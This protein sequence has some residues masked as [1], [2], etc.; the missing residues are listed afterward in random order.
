MTTGMVLKKPRSS[1]LLI[2]TKF[3]MDV[4]LLAPEPDYLLDPQFMDAARALAATVMKQGGD[5]D[6]AR[7]EFA[8]RQVVLRKPATNESSILLRR[9]TE[10]RAIFKQNPGKAA[11]VIKPLTFEPDDELDP[12]EHAAWTV[13]AGVILNLDEFITR[14]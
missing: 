13:V 2:A 7:L 12:V 6:E 8:Y 11:A 5:T 3:G 4:T 14:E 10:S 1:S 9:L